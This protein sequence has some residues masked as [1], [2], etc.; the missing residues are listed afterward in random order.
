MFLRPS[1][2]T[3]SSYTKE[4]ILSFSAVEVITSA[5]FDTFSHPVD[6]GLYDERMGPLRHDSMCKTC[7]LNY[8]DCVGHF[9][10]ID[11]K[12]VEF[13]PMFIDRIVKTLRENCIKKDCV[14]KA[15]EFRSGKKAMNKNGRGDSWENS[16]NIYVR[17]H[18]GENVNRW[19]K[20]KESGENEFIKTDIKDKTEKEREF[21]THKN[22]A[23]EP[24]QATESKISFCHC[25]NK[26]L[27]NTTKI[28]INE[29][30]YLP[31]QI[32]EGLRENGVDCEKWF[33][34]VLPVVPNR[35]R[36]VNFSMGKVFEDVQNAVLGKILKIVNNQTTDEDN[37][38]G[39]NN[40][41]DV[42]V[43][44]G[45]NEEKDVSLVVKSNSN[46][47]NKKSTTKIEFHNALSG[48]IFGY[49]DS[50]EPTSFGLK[51]LIE[52]KDGLFRKHVLGKRVNYAAR[53]VIAPDPHLGTGEIG[54]PLI[55]A[56]KLTVPERVTPFNVETLKKAVRNGSVWPGATFV[57]NNDTLISLGHISNEARASIAEQLGIGDKIVHRHLMNKDAVLL[58][59][60]PTL[61]R[62]SF[63]SHRVRVIPREKT[64]RLHYANCKAYNADFDGDEMNVHLP[65]CNLAKSEC[66]NLVDT[67]MNYKVVTSGTP[68]RGLVQDHVVAAVL[69]SK[70]ILKKNDYEMLLAII[71][72]KGEKKDARDVFL[73]K[74]TDDEILNL[75]SEKHTNVKSE[76]S[77]KFPNKKKSG[78]VSNDIGQPEEQQRQIGFKQDSDFSYTRPTIFRPV[79]LYM[80]RQLI[81]SLLISNGFY[82]D[83]IIRS[84]L[85]GSNV[86][87]KKGCFISGVLDKNSMGV[88]KKC[89]VDVVGEVYGNNN[90][91]V[92]MTIMSRLFN[93]YLMLKG[94]TLGMDDLVVSKDGIKNKENTIL[95]YIGVTD[96][97]VNGM[98]CEDRKI[99]NAD[100]NEEIKCYYDTPNSVPFYQNDTKLRL[101]DTLVK[102]SLSRIKFNV[103]DHQVKR[104]NALSLIVLSGAKGSTVNINQMCGYLG[105]QELEGRRVP[106]TIIGKSLTVLSTESGGFVRNCFLTG[107]NY[108]SYFYHCMAGREG[109]IDT[110]VKTARSGYLQ[111][112]LMKHMEG[113]TV[114]YNGCVGSEGSFSRKYREGEKR[115]RLISY[116]YYTDK[117]DLISFET[118]TNNNKTNENVTRKESFGGQSSV[119][120]N[121]LNCSEL[122]TF[123][124]SGK[125]YWFSSAVQPGDAVGVNAAHSIG[126]PSTQMTLNTFH[127]AGV[128]SLNMTLGVPRLVEIVM[129]GGS[130]KTPYL[131]LK[132]FSSHN[133]LTTYNVQLTRCVYFMTYKE[134]LEGFMQRKITIELKMKDG[135]GLKETDVEQK[136]FDA[137]TK[138]IKKI[139]MRGILRGIRKKKNK[140][141]RGDDINEESNKNIVEEAED[142]EEAKNKEK[143]SDSD[144]ETDSSETQIEVESFNDES[145]DKDSCDVDSFDSN[146][147]KN[148]EEVVYR[149]PKVEEIYNKIPEKKRKK[150]SVFNSI[151]GFV[152]VSFIFEDDI[153]YVPIVEAAIR[154]IIIN[155]LHGVKNIRF[156]ADK[157]LFEGSN[158]AVLYQLIASGHNIDA[159]EFNGCYTNDISS[160]LRVLGIEAAKAAIVKEL[161]LVLDAYGIE[162]LPCHINLLSDYMTC[163]GRVVALNRRG[164]FDSELQKMCFESCYSVLRN[165]VE[166][167]DKDDIINPSACQVVG[168][169]VKVGTNFFEVDYDFEKNE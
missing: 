99:K 145:V 156:L 43:N 52:R 6:N 37:K 88:S 117:K 48:A 7:G 78:F 10:Y 20:T 73:N 163:S 133:Y 24:D 55:F 74:N 90:V 115:G 100:V 136:V 28:F 53:S 80:G 109:L 16:K 113:V 32:R 114:W 30:Q 126:E 111:R 169:V 154:E 97:I 104:N 19:K 93:R 17:N 83:C 142:V 107:I 8:Y 123:G 50:N 144:V 63:M 157:T 51:Q 84:K 149:N 158:F 128:G 139:R 165:C 2:M 49:F 70:D 22:A 129:N 160:V 150:S 82:I 85:D 31:E 26:I 15:K 110:A 124:D 106:L 95:K 121:N 137:V 131:S 146:S 44:N 143:N 161:Q 5:T 134:E 164:I 116:E 25:K 38:N 153:F 66:I 42:N 13:H 87:F 46:N 91:D 18:A 127:L 21:L 125:V 132:R 67:S 138:K 151:P 9:G 98:V 122:G 47:P 12:N 166:N 35:F 3:F 152:R 102:N 54:I 89:I 119:F 64:L 86:I 167:E 40:T 101:M 155:P 118:P 103:I 112:C 94:F 159:S 62:C 140:T 76:N 75:D 4:E 105:Q 14:R 108:H 45:N 147:E 60:Q 92:V 1:E 58:N 36:P 120:E 65:Q 96:E 141:F 59:R 135:C 61:H 81:S 39:K 57:R 148:E 68:V 69:L 71:L 56:K 34:E 77:G 168:N 33:I 27:R 11:L 23:N 29:L 162:V 130:T 72:L 41:D 79:K